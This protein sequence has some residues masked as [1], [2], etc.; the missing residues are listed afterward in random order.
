M[1]SHSKLPIQCRNLIYTAATSLQ[2]LT[3]TFPNPEWSPTSSNTFQRINGTLSFYY[4]TSFHLVTLSAS[5]ATPGQDITGLLYN[6]TLPPGNAACLSTDDYTTPTNV[7]RRSNLPNTDYD[8]VAIAPWGSP[9]CVLKYLNAVQNDPIRGFLFF[10]PNNSSDTPPNAD[11]STWNLGDNDD[12]KNQFHFPVYAVP[13]NSGNILMRASAD[14]S[15]N[16]TDVPHGH[17]L[18]EYYDSRDYV[19]LFA[20]VNTSGGTTL[21]S[22]WVFLLVVLGILLSVIG[23]TSLMMHLLQRR[24]RQTLRRRVANGEVDLEALGIKRLTVPQDILDKMPLYT[25]GDGVPVQP[26]ARSVAREGTASTAVR[27]SDVLGKEETVAESSRTPRRATI[28]T[29]HQPTCAI[30]LD[31]F[32]AAATSS[33]GTIQGTIV[34]ELPCR[35]IFHPECVDTF[36]R[37]NSSLC[38]MCKKTA[39]PKGYCPRVVTNAMVRRERMVRRIRPRASSADIDAEVEAALAAEDRRGRLPYSVS[40]A[41]GSGP[42]PIARSASVTWSTHG[43]RI[44]SSDPRRASAQDGTVE[45][46]MTELPSSS[47]P[48]APPPAAVTSP[49]QAQG[50]QPSSNPRRREWARQRAIAM[51]GRQRAPVDPEAE[52]EARTPRWRKAVRTLFP[53]AR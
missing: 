40:A 41:R 43:G 30:C 29:L 34:R 13:G 50:V 51:L 35:H 2:V 19:R 17:L 20:D 26:T 4:L 12:W 45:R 18:T 31:D 48:I 14:Y 5:S 1:G 53:G 47:S 23:L 49:S 37:D 25:Y 46:E 10:V 7:T 42:V 33:S 52:E 3:V 24:R 28:S 38:P 21:P 6:P 9:S 8:L 11:S 22:L 27:E 16:M 36:L 32:V 39:L 15:G 44:G